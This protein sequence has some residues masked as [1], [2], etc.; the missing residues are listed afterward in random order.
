LACGLL[1]P[2]NPGLA[3]PTNKN[4]DTVAHLTRQEREDITYKAQHALRLIA[5]NVSYINI[6]Y[7]VI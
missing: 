2:G 1:L 7:F 3:D 6:K 5:F 4:E